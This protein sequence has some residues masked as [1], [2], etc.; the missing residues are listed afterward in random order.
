MSG[1][2]LLRLSQQ[3]RS[4]SACRVCVR[5]AIFAEKGAGAYTHMSTA[6]DKGA[7]VV[8][9]ST[10]KMSGLGGAFAN[11][12]NQIETAQ[13]TLG[14]KFSPALQTAF[15]RVVCVHPEGDW[16]ADGFG[17]GRWVVVDR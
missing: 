1:C 2:R 7:G 6:I 14:E 8:A 11:V 17:A 15:G 9:F 10:A 5:R 3:R 4:L 12:K 16:V 13:V